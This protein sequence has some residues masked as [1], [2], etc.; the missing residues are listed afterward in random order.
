MYVLQ[1]QVSRCCRVCVVEYDVVFLTPTYLYR[2]E[3]FGAAIT[4]SSSS[5]ALT[6][7]SFTGNTSPSGGAVYAFGG[8][9]SVINSGRSGCG[10]IVVDVVVGDCVHVLP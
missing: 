3:F 7:C 6:N 8:A 9:L 4:S 5:P 1:Q 2:N 10:V